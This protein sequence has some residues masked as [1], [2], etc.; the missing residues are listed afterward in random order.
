MADG[1]LKKRS[2]VSGQKRGNEIQGLFSIYIKNLFPGIRLIGLHFT[3]ALAAR[4][5]LQKTRYAN[6]KT[7]SLPE[8]GKQSL[9]LFL[10]LP[11]YFFEAFEGEAV[12][13]VDGEGFLEIGLG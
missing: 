6:D 12:A 3:F 4:P 7:V 11:L 13:G 8:P 10:L 2:Q 9:F 1:I 5:F